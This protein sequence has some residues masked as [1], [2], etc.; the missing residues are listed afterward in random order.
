MRG[1]RH[2]MALTDL[3][4]WIRE[5]D[6]AQDG[7]VW[8]IQPLSA[9]DTLAI[10]AR[11]GGP[12]H[13]ERLTF[14]VFPKIDRPTEKNPNA[15]FDLYVAGVCVVRASDRTVRVASEVSAGRRRR[16][17]PCVRRIGVRQAP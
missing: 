3:T 13:A 11:R 5:N 1:G 4:D 17:R 14:E 16:S 8:C 12:I 10:G 2:H 9:N 7:V 15:E 6:F